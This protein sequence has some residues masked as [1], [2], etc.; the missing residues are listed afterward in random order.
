MACLRDRGPGPEA[1][2]R[3]GK[4]LLPAKSGLDTPVHNAARH[5]HVV[6]AVPGR[7]VIATSAGSSRKTGVRSGVSFAGGQTALWNVELSLPAM[8]RVWLGGRGCQRAKQSRQEASFG[9]SAGLQPALDEVKPAVTA[10]KPGRVAGRETHP[11][12]RSQNG[13]QA[14]LEIVALQRL[15]D[16]SALRLRPFAPLRSTG[17][18]TACLSG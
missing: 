4:R 2:S 3:F 13:A 7:R 10:L 17:R 1:R 15:N 12:S 11:Q 5:R 6:V 18:P 9:R 8:R 14:R 16:F